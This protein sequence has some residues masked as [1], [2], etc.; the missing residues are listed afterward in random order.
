M[1][2][3]SA[4]LSNRWSFQMET[5]G[6][7]PNCL[8]GPLAVVTRLVGK[9]LAAVNAIFLV[10]SSIFQFTG[11]YDNCWCD[12]CVPSLGREAGWVVLFASD[13]EIAA[14]SKSAWIGGV[15]MSVLSAVLAA[16]FF[17]LSRGDEIFK[18]NK[19]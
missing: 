9:S 12:A 18:H 17:F 5:K 16:C 3:L 14:A 11:L 15:S 13:T 2:I 4:A 10:A 7:K 1:L 19:Q 6:I 8:L